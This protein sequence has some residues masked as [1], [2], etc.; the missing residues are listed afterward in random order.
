MQYLSNIS[1][2]IEQASID[3]C[4]MD[5]TSIAH[6]YPSPE[7]AA[8]AIKD[9]ICSRFGFTVNIGISN[10]KVLSKMASDFE[11]PNL[12]HTLYS[13]EIEK[14]CGRF[15]SPLYLCADIPVSIPYKSWELLPSAI[16]QRQIPL[17][18]PLI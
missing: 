8:A 18:Y 9:E 4:Y 3:E 17:L 2:D 6:L 5:F 1:P 15:L 10:K 11:K 16:W 13:R 14:S 12:V 7:T